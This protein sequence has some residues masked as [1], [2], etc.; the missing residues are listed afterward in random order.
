ML[1]W[2]NRTQYHNLGPRSVQLPDP[3]PALAD[4]RLAASLTCGHGAGIC[5]A[6]GCDDGS[7]RLCF[8]RVRPGS[9]SYRRRVRP[10]GV[11]IT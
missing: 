11:E 1:G 2:E 9:R 4:P 3:Y 6:M 8:R 7:V 10:D 5:P